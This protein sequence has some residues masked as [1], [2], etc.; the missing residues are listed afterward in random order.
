MLMIQDLHWNYILGS[1]TNIA[2]YVISSSLIIVIHDNMINM[3][4]HIV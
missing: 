3:T 4:N 2:S 1:Y